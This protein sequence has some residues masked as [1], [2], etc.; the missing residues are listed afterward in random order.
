M[1]DGI[2][3]SPPPGS[4]EVAKAM[5]KSPKDMR[6]WDDFEHTD[7]LEVPQKLVDQ[8]IGQDKAVEIIKKASKQR[9]NV[10]LIGEP[11]TGKSMLANAMTELLPPSELVDILAYPN[12]EDENNPKIRT[13]PTGEG[14]KIVKAGRDKE[15]SEE[16]SKKPNTGLIIAVFLILPMLVYA[17]ILLGKMHYHDETT[18]IDA[19][20]FVLIMGLGA[21]FLLFSGMNFR[22]MMMGGNKSNVPRLIVDNSSK[23]LAPFFDGTGAHAGALLGDIKHDPLQSGGLG[24]PAHLRVVSGL[25]HKTNKGVLFIDEIGTLGKSQQDLL[26]ALQEKQLPITGRSEMSS[27]AMVITDPVP[28]DFILVAAGNYNV[29]EHMHPALRSRIRGYGYEI[30]MEDLMEDTDNSRKKIV[31]FVAQEV[32]RD[33]KIPHFTR[34]ACEEIILEA[35]RR[36]GTKNKLTLKFRDL[37]GLIRAAGDIGSEKKHTYVSRDDVVDG[38]RSAR[39]LEQQMGD[40]YTI[41]RKEYNVL[42]TEGQKV[43]RVNGLAVRGDAGTVLPIEAEVAVGGEKSQIIATGKLGDIAKEAVLNVSAVIMKAYGEDI[44]EKY[45]IFVQ[46]LQTY[47]GVEGDS[48]SVS[49]AVAVISAL[50]N[51]PIDQS[52]AMTGSLTVRGE[53]LPV[54][55]VTPKVE[56]AIEA[57]LKTVII[58]KSNEKDIMLEKRY[59]GKIRIVTAETLVDVLEHS[60]IGGKDI[61]NKMRTSILSVPAAV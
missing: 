6:S 58:P 11:G 52:V 41:R 39:T 56:A 3:V 44:K 57:G 33:G 4:R 51:V 40:V 36:A 10:L 13:V 45:D 21:M 30:Y 12:Y 37:G 9:R 23:K 61:I 27:G 47:D 35:K 26:T 1:E 7:E 34:D 54:G 5:K 55:G 16:N 43:G 20:P 42:I 32:E 48:A 59:E 49:V 38:K 22:G 17:A 24:T 46:F 29:M 53:V 15:A 19:M 50:K 14:V 28:C 25:I 31:Q 60:F 8:V 18:P 2:R